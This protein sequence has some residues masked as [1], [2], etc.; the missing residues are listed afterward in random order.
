[1]IV[2]MLNWGQLPGSSRHMRIGN[3][4]GWLSLIVGGDPAAAALLAE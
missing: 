2:I 1:M 3:L 4:A